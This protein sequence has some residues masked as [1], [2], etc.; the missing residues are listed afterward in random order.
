MTRCVGQVHVTRTVFDLPIYC[1]L[2]QESTSLIFNVNIVTPFSR[3]D[4]AN[5]N[6]NSSA[7]VIQTSL[8]KKA[9]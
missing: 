8:E 1:A 9:K 6:H 3:S 2:W 4:N 5:N 7:D